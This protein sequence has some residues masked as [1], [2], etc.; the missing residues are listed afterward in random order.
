MLTHS[1]D[2]RRAGREHP[3]ARQR[4]AYPSDVE[5]L[6]SRRAGRRRRTPGRRRRCRAQV[7]GALAPR[8]HWGKRSGCLPTDGSGTARSCGAT[9]RA[10]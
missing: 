2:G 1:A 8:I 3:A 7:P 5:R 6:F 9:A 4:H 10:R